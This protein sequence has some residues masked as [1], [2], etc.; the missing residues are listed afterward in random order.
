MKKFTDFLKEKNSRDYSKRKDYSN[1]HLGRPSPGSRE[2]TP[3]PGHYYEFYL[4]KWTDGGKI[5]VQ[6]LSQD[7]KDALERH[8]QNDLEFMK[9][10][11]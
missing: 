7:K 3:F 11:K 9:K 2:N 4:H 10:Q 6:D 1:Y 8:K 5:K